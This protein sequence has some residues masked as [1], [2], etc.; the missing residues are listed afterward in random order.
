M[1]CFGIEL[2]F[3][4]GYEKT[5]ESRRIEL[6]SAATRIYSCLGL[7]ED[8]VWVNV[9]HNT[10]KSVLQCTGKIM[11][12]SKCGRGDLKIL[13]WDNHMWRDSQCQAFARSRKVPP[14]KAVDRRPREGRNL[15]YCLGI[16]SFG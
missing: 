7:S 5:P 10:K 16:G 14:P 4:V 2:R 12:E 3:S 1:P 11:Y 15:V 6:W 13:R 9:I 8:Y